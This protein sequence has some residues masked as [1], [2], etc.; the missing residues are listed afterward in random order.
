MR[1]RP[2]AS[3]KGPVR[4]ATPLYDT[5]ALQHS[6]SAYVDTQGTDKAFDLGVYWT[7]PVNFAVR[8]MGL[9]YCAALISCILEVIVCYKFDVHSW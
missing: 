4:K 5:R 8:G 1:N 9:L 2:R 7:I 6:L 3:G